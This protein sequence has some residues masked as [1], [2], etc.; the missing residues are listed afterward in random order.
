MK[1][2]LRS[3]LLVVCLATIFSIFFAST[4]NAENAIIGVETLNVRSGPGLTNETIGQVHEKETYQVVKQSGNWVKI[5]MG[6]KQGWVAKWL[7]TIQESPASVKVKSKVDQLRIRSGAGTNYKVLSYMDKGEELPK[8]DVKGDWVKVKW[9]DQT[10][11]VHGNYIEEVSVTSKEQQ[12]ISTT[13]QMVNVNA[14]NVRKGPNLSSDL[15]DQLTFGTN[16]TIL[17]K[18]ED[19]VEVKYDEK[20][21]WIASQFLTDPKKQTN[22]K[23]QG[24]VIVDTP[25][26]NVRSQGSLTGDIIGQ[27][28]KGDKLPFYTEDKSW[29]QVKLPDGKIG[30]IA[31]WLAKEQ[32]E[33][34]EYISLMYNATNLRK[35]PS[36]DY[37][38]VGRGSKGEAF[39]IIKKH[40]KWYEIDWNGKSAF[41][42]GWIVTTN[43]GKPE[44]LTEEKRIF[45]EKTIVIDPG[46]GGR[47]TGT[48]SI[49]GQYEKSLTLQVALQ[50]AE[51]LRIAGA[52]VIMTRDDDTYLS[53]S[54]R[55]TLSNLS[56]ADA[57]IS[58]HFNSAPQYP[59]VSGI[60]TYFYHTKDKQFALDVQ[61][62]MIKETGMHNREVRFGDFHVI[63]ENQRPALLLELGFLS[64]KQDQE[65]VK[66]KD[67]REKVTKGIILGLRDYF[68]K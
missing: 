10:G 62:A 42:A 61:N 50:L 63:R 5:Q 7:V 8:L 11:W 19:W 68:E 65:F 56:N 20:T 21:G 45:N 66:T 41:V 27:V 55:A 16:V 22:N 35:G 54:S 60:G 37:D 47:D 39:K 15:I 31:N 17:S 2:N 38:I 32:Q 25:I 12:P 36:T 3:S 28:N 51:K 29:Y 44:F 9:N 34:Q 67:F 6:Q 64:N 14:L 4:V 52:K 48:I 58:L 26:L 57:F 30:W 43:Q 40:D 24:Y 33:K 53:L 59:N 18:K 49:N 46:H 1:S 23:E 13:I